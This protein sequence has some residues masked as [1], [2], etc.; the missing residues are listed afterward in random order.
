MGCNLIS[1]GTFGAFV[2]FMCLAIL[3]SFCSGAL[4]W[5]E[6]VTKPYPGVDFTISLY[7]FKLCYDIS[8]PGIA[9][10]HECSYQSSMCDYDT[11][12]SSLTSSEI[13]L[14]DKGCSAIKRGTA[15]TVFFSL[16]GC[17]GLVGVAF[18]I[19]DLIK[20]GEI[21]LLLFI[22]CGCL[23][24][25][26]VLI[27]IAGPMEL[28]SCHDIND[29]MKKIEYGMHYSAG[30]ATFG[31]ALAAAITGIAL[32]IAYVF[33]RSKTTDEVERTPLRS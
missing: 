29:E 14:N 23:A 15:S 12:G 8:A 32:H 4:P 10:T 27:V 19:F 16:A 5:M 21:R 1:Y 30:T 25:S 11:S 13:S 3:C 18:A 22:A 28:S 20:R 33:F 24:I 2:F 26:A 7:P 17:F 6:R 31:L 9:D